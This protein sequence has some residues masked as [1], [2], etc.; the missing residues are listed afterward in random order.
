MFTGIIQH[1]VQV[2]TNKISNGTMHLTVK[3]DSEIIEH[4]SLGA[5]IAINGVCLTAVEFH[6]ESETG[7]VSFDVIDE[8]LRVSNLANIKEGDFVNLERSLKV[9]DELGGHIIS[10]HVHTMA[11]LQRR[12]ESENNCQLTFC[13][14]N[15][16]G[17]YLFA[18]GFV[19]INGISLTLGEVENGEFN[20]HLI[21][22]TLA[23]TNLDKLEVDQQVNIEFDQQTM[24]IV[25]TL[26]RMN[27]VR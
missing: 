25:S 23:R 13:V 21:P 18:K 26:E 17:K 27:L 5:S 12:V 10:G 3:G 1:Q 20:V 11:R 15:E 6:L 4:L 7:I 14:E 16:W 22:E 2:I 19:S 8:T 24:T 9:G